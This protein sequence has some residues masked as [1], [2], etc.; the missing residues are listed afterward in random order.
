[1]QQR[2]ACCIVSD[3]AQAVEAEKQEGTCLL[4]KSMNWDLIF[5]T[6]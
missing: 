3:L 1:M 6:C 2:C 4:G 5:A